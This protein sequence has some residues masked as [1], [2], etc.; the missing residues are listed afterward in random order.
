MSN[1]CS[2]RPIGLQ[3]FLVRIDENIVREN[4]PGI[5]ASII[6][7]INVM[8]VSAWRSLPTVVVY[9]IAIG[10]EISGRSPSAYNRSEVVDDKINKF[11]TGSKNTR[12]VR[13]RN[14]GGER[15]IIRRKTRFIRR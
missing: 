1:R 8:A 6:L 13:P 14:R 4:F 2:R 11:N 15:R 7:T 10:F 5:T 9:D 12:A 3:I